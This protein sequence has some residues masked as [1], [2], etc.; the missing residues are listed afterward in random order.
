MLGCF[1]CC[2][3]LFNI[4]FWFET[5]KNTLD[6]KRVGGLYGAPGPSSVRSGDDEADDQNVASYKMLCTLIDE[7]IQ[8]PSHVG[9]CK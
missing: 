5:Q 8:D 9:L 2:E 7:I 3:F 4:D 6:V 1:Y